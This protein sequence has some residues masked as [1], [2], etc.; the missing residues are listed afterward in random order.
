MMN[1]GTTITMD[2]RRA[3]VCLFV[4]SPTKQE[5]RYQMQREKLSDRFQTLNEHH[6]TIAEIFED[7]RGHIGDD[8]VTTYDSDQLRRQFHITPGQF[9][10][11]LVSDAAVRMCA[12][13]CISCEEVIM[14][15]ENQPA[16]PKHAGL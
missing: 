4:F 14:R 11:V 12:E 3:S 2:P 9:K 8:E 16:E 1:T 15:V 10:V 7:E 6:V 5:R 13:S